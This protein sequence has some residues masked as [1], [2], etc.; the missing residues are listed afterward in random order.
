MSRT[1]LK[2]TTAGDGGVGKTTLLFR[3]VRG[4]YPW[5]H[6]PIVFESWVDHRVVDGNEVD[7]ELWDVAG[8][9]EYDQLRPLGYHDTN[10]FVLCF[11]LNEPSSF[12]NVKER[13][14][15]ELSQHCPRTPILLVGTKED[16]RD[17][18][19]VVSQLTM[20][21]LSP[22]TYRQGLECARDIGA[23]KYM[24][25]SSLT[26]KGVQEVFVEA[27]RAALRIREEARQDSRKCILQ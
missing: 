19:E 10:V 25:C 2:F 8:S 17:D 23:V 24:E 13:W 3:Y 7:I 15:P 6:I 18:P 21:D 9:E 14:Y 1:Y 20:R 26:D 27:A 16:L 11:S 5:D 22:I 12:T 4:S